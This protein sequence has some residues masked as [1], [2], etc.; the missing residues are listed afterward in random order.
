V[1]T[2]TK[3][4]QER[5]EL[6][7]QTTQPHNLNFE[8]DSVTSK[9]RTKKRILN[10]PIMR[11]QEIRAAQTKMSYCDPV[12]GV[13]VVIAVVGGDCGIINWRNETTTLLCLVDHNRCNDWNRSFRGRDF[14]T[15]G[16]EK[17]N[18]RHHM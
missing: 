15:L 7:K 5:S 11:Y 13:V 16:T 10:N 4:Q 17:H 14:D 2:A 6:L 3:A 12:A 18:K 9:R 8:I 1:A